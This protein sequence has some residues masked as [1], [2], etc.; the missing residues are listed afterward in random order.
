MNEDPSE[1]G[2]FVLPEIKEVS[3]EEIQAQLE[4]AFEECWGGLDADGAG[5]LGTDDV[6]K[7]AAEV[8]A[9]MT[10]AEEAEINEEA[11]DEAFGAVEKTEDGNT[12]KDKCKAFFIANF[13]KL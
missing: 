9:K 3:P 12:E 2:E 6:K 13:A 11:F 10:G 4:A 1:Y 5:N 8:K 7:L